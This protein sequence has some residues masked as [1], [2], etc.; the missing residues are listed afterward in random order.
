MPVRILYHG[1]ANLEIHSGP[2]RLQIDPFYTGNPLADIDHTAVKPTCILLTH[3]HGDHVGDTL[4]IVKRTKAPIIANFEMCNYLSQHG[5]PHVLPINHGGSA[6][7]PG[8]NPH[9]RATM[10]L[11]FHS[12]T[13]PDGT[14]GGQPAGFI[15]QVGD[16]TIYHAGDTALFGDMRLLGEMYSIDLACLPIGDCF[17][18]NPFAAVKAAQFLRAKKVLPIHYN[19]FPPIQ[20]DPGPFLAELNTLGIQ[21]VALK[22][23]ASLDL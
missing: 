11:A 21:G 15:I 12:S 10:T 6:Q 9:E 7:L 17:T 5:A 1:H 16:K 2:H 20:Q 18:M 19:T 13:F 22:P 23:G 3:A 8:G 14:Y 4:A